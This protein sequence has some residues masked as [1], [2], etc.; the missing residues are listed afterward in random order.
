MPTFQQQLD[1]PAGIVEVWFHDT[2]L[3]EC[4]TYSYRVRLVMI[5]PLFGLFGVVAD[6]TDAAAVTLATAWSVWSEPVTV[7]R[8]TEFFVAEAGGGGMVPVDVFTMKWGQRV[9]Q[10]FTVRQGEPIGGKATVKLWKLGEQE[11]VDVEVDFAT[12]AIAVDLAFG[13]KRPVPNSVIASSTTELLYLNVDGQLRTRTA[14]AD[15]ESERY[16]KLIGEA[17]WLEE[18]QPA[19]PSG[20]LA[21]PGARPG[22]TSRTKRDTGT[23]RRT[24]GSG[25]RTRDQ[26]AQFGEP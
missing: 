24:G 7:K 4:V 8:P 26:R 25:A 15:R 13:K 23:L 1:D 20:V 16:K 19:S 18:G 14:L 11:L 12:G 22:L 2:K 17:T 6:K 9:K 10:N 5:N 3:R 21:R